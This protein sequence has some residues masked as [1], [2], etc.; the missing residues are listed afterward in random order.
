MSEWVN[1]DISRLKSSVAFKKPDFTLLP[2][3][4]GHGHTQKIEFRH[5]KAGAGSGG[6]AH[7]PRTR[8]LILFPLLEDID[9]PLATNG[10]DP[11]TLL[12]QEEV[13]GVAGDFRFAD[14][15]S[16]GRIQDQQAGRLSAA[17]EEALV[18][19]IQGEGKILAGLRKRP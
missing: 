2:W 3:P 4:F 10:I 17:D 19:F 13:V 5:K 11:R 8:P 16:A 1:G 9:G 18:G 15:L 7:L 14:D 12:I 6:C